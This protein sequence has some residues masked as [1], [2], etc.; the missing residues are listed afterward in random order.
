[1]Q[2]VINQ[3][4]QF[5]AINDLGT[6]E[7]LPKAPDAHFQM[8]LD[9]IQGRAQGGKS[10]IKGAT[11]FFNPDTSDPSW[12]APIRKNPTA[13]FGRPRNSH[14]HGF[15]DG[16]HPP[17]GYAIQLGKHSS[18]FTGDGQPRGQL[19]SPDKSVPSIIAAASKEWQ[20]WGQSTPGRIA[21]SDNEQ[22]FAMYVR[23]RYCSPL[24]AS[25]SLADIEN[26][27]YAWSAV[28]IS[29]FLRQAGLSSSEFT[30]SQRHST[31]IR[32]AVKARNDRDR[33]KAFWGF[34]LSES[35]AVVAPGDIIGRAREG[36]MSF[37]QAQAL[38][39]KHEDYESHSDV[40]VAVRAG[41]AELI[42]GNVSDSVTKRTIA[43][44]RRGKVSDK[45]SLAFV[46]MKK[47]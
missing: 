29:Y 20:F 23:D 36:S 34:R 45:R 13:R 6:W 3:K 14:I 31:Y 8:V 42:G 17:E 40:V 35:D 21:H 24:G 15:P 4:S 32:E 18:V 10:E 2:G 11:H 12:G 41:V 39:D 38:F 7:R 9:Y 43:L 46:V 1:M 37:D 27:K 25:P 26:D 30:F 28:A 16:F 22:D 5:S 33:S 47:N 19:I 44:D